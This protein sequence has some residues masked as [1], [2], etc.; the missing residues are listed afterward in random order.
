MAGQP[1]AFALM[2]PPKSEAPRGRLHGRAAFVAVDPGRYLRAVRSDGAVF[3]GGDWFALGTRGQGEHLAD[4]DRVA[5][6]LE[7]GRRHHVEDDLRLGIHGH[8]VL[9]D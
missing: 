7:A 5:D 1:P 9:L 8:G 6:E 3:Y 2:R 4:G